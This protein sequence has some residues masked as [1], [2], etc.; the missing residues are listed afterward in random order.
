MS[1]ADRDTP[2]GDRGASSA[3]GSEGRITAP[4]VVT[5]PATSTQNQ[6]CHCLG[7]AATPFCKAVSWAWW[8]AR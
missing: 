1:E 4:A 2:N 6:C 7:E 8:A 3:A 5:M